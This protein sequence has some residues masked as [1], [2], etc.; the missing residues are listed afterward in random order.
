[1]NCSATYSNNNR[2]K[3]PLDKYKNCQTCNQPFLTKRTSVKR[4][5]DSCLQKTQEISRENSRKKAANKINNCIVCQVNIISNGRAKYCK[6]CR[7]EIM[8]KSAIKRINNPNNSKNLATIHCY[9]LFNN[10]LIRCDSK[11]EYSCINYLINNFQIINI[12]RCKTILP[13]QLD[14]KTKNYNPDFEVSLLNGKIMIVECKAPEADGLSTRSWWKF[15][16]DSIKPKAEALEKYCQ[17]VGYDILFYTKDLNRKF[18]KSLNRED[19]QIKN[20]D[21]WELC[22]SLPLAY[23]I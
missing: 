20:V 8:S 18:Y 17:E 7:S 3:E 5:C 10:E 16:Y 22:S 2:A 12:K 15:Y 1:M 6:S 21:V 11:V 4:K 13:Y 23:D 9:Y 14:N 19:L